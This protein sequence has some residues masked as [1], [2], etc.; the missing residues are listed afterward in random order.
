MRQRC[1]SLVFQLL[2]FD[3]HIYMSV[4]H[5][6]HPRGFGKSSSWGERRFEEGRRVCCVQYIYVKRHHGGWGVSTQVYLWG[7]EM[8]CWSRLRLKQLQHQWGDIKFPNPIFNPVCW[9][10]ILQSS[11]IRA[12]N[13]IR[14]ITSYQTG[15]QEWSGPAALTLEKVTEFSPHQE[16][17]A[18]PLHPE[19][20]GW[21]ESRA[22]S[23]LILVIPW[24]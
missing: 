17:T 8:A 15:R 1:Y 14:K 9:V 4:T 5:S 23:H 19:G 6:P 18:S 10:L 13:W 3:T 12:L 22:L 21:S 16:V 7:V 2:I 24:N 20:A 11:S